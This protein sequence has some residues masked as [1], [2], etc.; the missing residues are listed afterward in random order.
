MD[1]GMSSRSN[2]Y[3]VLTSVSGAGTRTFP[4]HVQHTQSTFLIPVQMCG[5]PPRPRSPLLPYFTSPTSRTT[6]RRLHPLPHL[7]LLRMHHIRL[8]FYPTLRSYTAQQITPPHSQPFPRPFPRLVTHTPP[9]GGGT[10][11]PWQLW[12]WHWRRM[13]ASTMPMRIVITPITVYRV[14]LNLGIGTRGRQ[15]CISCL[16]KQPELDQTWLRELDWK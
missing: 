5:R 3:N 6:P 8:C 10:I 9:P 2:T 4:L 11:L 13:I 16:L 12:A 15:L 1:I 7:R 14:R